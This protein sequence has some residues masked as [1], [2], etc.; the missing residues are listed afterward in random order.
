MNHKYLCPSCQGNRSRFYLIKKLAQEVRIDPN[1]GK[2]VWAADEWEDVLDDGE[3]YLEVRCALCGYTSR[4]NVFTQAA[5]NLGA[6]NNL[7][8]D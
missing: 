6:S 2:I 5:K 7:A 4:E 1:T 3:L 8:I